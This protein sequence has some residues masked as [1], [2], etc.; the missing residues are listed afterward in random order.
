MITVTIPPRLC[1]LFL[2]LKLPASSLG[3]FVPNLSGIAH[4]GEEVY[5]SGYGCKLNIKEKEQSDMNE[6]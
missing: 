5:L 2:L 4:G 3:E 6:E 1:I